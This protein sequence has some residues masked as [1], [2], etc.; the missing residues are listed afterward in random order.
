MINNSI[1][2]KLFKLL[3]VGLNY[4]PTHNN[5]DIH[6]TLAHS[7]WS[8]ML[9]VAKQHGVKY[10]LYEAID[11]LPKHLHPDSELHIK[12]YVETVKAEERFHFYTKSIEQLATLMSAHNLPMLVIK[13]YTIAQL[14]P[15]P[16]RREGGDID[17]FLFGK[18]QTGE[19]IIAKQHGDNKIK[20]KK[21]R[22][23]HSQFVFNGIG[24]DN[25]INFVKDM[26]GLTPKL[27]LFYDRI[28]KIIQKS[29]SE[30]NIDVI[31]IGTQKI[32]TLNPNTTAIYMTTHLFRHIT[33]NASSI[34]H[35]CDWVVFFNYYR[36]QLDRELLTTQIKECGLSKFV[37]N[38][39]AFCKKR[40]EYIPFLDFG[41]EYKIYEGKRSI[42]QIV[43]TFSQ[44]NNTHNTISI[45]KNS[46]KKIISSQKCY[47]EYLGM[48]NYFDYFIPNI[49][50]RIIQ[51]LKLKI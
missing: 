51:L 37:A 33:A 23:K 28:E 36:N 9:Q 16:E 21:K 39:E 11:K 30:G 47:A 32:Y 20:T 44:D 49:F 29:I 14:Y 48:T 25:H 41:D 50:A 10:L 45:V 2:D 13:G 27:E 5:F 34:R 12:C 43:L 7:D 15:S 4:T 22:S 35:F 3:C 6:P 26:S 8:K 31:T 24:V 40:F 18:H 42:E 1:Y 46:L 17:I 38:V 19:Q